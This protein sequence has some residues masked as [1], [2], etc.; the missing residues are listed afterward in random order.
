MVGPGASFEP[1]PDPDATDVAHP[2]DDAGGRARQ[3]TRRRRLVVAGAVVAWTGAAVAGG[4]AIGT[5]QRVDP[6]APPASVVV[7]V[8]QVAVPELP[9]GET[10]VPVV[11]M[12][13]VLGL[14]QADAL[15]VLGDSG[16]DPGTVTIGSAP[17]AGDSGLVVGQ[18]P[19]PGTRDPAEVTLSVSAPVGVPNVVGALVD[20]AQAQLE[21]L[22]AVVRIQSAYQ[23]DTPAGTVLATD[24][25]S[26]P[27]PAEVLM[28]VA[29][30]PASM[31]LTQLSPVERQD[32]S[33]GN[34]A[35][36]NGVAGVSAADCTV[37][38]LI[39]GQVA[40]AQLVG[41]DLSRLV[42]RVTFT[43]GFNDDAALVAAGTVEVFLDGVSVA[44]Q[45]V[46]FGAPATFDIEATGALRLTIQVSTSI[47]RDPSE[48]SSSSRLGV[49]SVIDGALSGSQTNITTLSDANP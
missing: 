16:L 46:A 19:P 25:A 2:T 35:K 37:D 47:V 4:V 3:R 44:A 8:Q 43:A 28:T 48:P 27:L 13:N 17:T 26:G 29:S 36:V 33:F 9:S 38:K 39:E 31:A 12:A 41:Y 21:Q 20:D 15:G 10:T 42:D 14:S 34:D 49:V 6:P 23:R 5:R 24:P 30:P 11:Q 7:E 22:G 45:P 40:E 18:D 1:G 32:C